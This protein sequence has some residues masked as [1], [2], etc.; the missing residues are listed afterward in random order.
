MTGTDGEAHD[1]LYDA[2]GQRRFKSDA[3]YSRG[4]PDEKELGRGFV[5][6][7]R[8]K[9]PALFS[10]SERKKL[11][12]GTHFVYDEASNLIGEYGDG[13]AQSAGQSEHI[14]LPT[15]T[16]PVLIGVKTR[17]HIYS[18]H[19]DHLG[20]PRL[21][22]D[23]P[24]KP[25]WQWPYSAFGDNAPVVLAGDTGNEDNAERNAPIGFAYN[26]RFSGQYFDRESGLHYNGQ[27]YYQ[28]TTGRYVNADP[29]GL[30]GGWNR[31][32]YVGGNPLMFTDPLGL[33]STGSPTLDR[34]LEPKT[35]P[36]NCVTGACAAGSPPTPSDNRSQKEMDFGQC[37][38]VCQISLLAPVAMCNFAAG[39]GLAGTAA[40]AVA[41]GG[42]CSWVCK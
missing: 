30:G 5:E 35:P 10:E 24:N 31:F 13:G 17:G 4:D 23:G 36:G 41:K 11:G 9:F 26:V 28:P 16:G 25:I 33:R 21:I 42:L 14:W 37:K 38:M 2:T 1:Y 18:V 6:W 29:I 3:V 20:T 27:R 32:A 12:A 8:G 19:A 34:W 22:A 39:G 40:T 15:A 7:L